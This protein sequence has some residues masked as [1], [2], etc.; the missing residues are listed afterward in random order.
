MLK[1]WREG[2]GKLC[3]C[4]CCCCCCYCCCLVAVPA[5]APDWHSLMHTIDNSCKHQERRNNTA[6]T[7]TAAAQQHSLPQTTGTSDQQSRTSFPAAAA[8]MLLPN[9]PACSC[10]CSQNTAAGSPQGRAGTPAKQKPT[11]H[12]FV[13]LHLLCY[14]KVT[15]HRVW[16]LCP[17]GA[18]P[19][20]RPPPWSHQW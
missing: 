4:C 12:L 1:N 16:L 14:N 9:L 2:G 3:R 19:Y 8:S 10:H 13:M 15:A 7:S 5:D 20:Q 6:P 18:P 11:I 17:T